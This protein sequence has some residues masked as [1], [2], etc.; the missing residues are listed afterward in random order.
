MHRFIPIVLLVEICSTL[1]IA[2]GTTDTPVRI[3]VLD[4]LAA[5]VISWLRYGASVAGIVCVLIGGLR[6]W[7]GY[8]TWSGRLLLAG[9]GLFVLA[10]IALS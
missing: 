4:E 10:Y 2:A 8:T 3:P 9:V 6:L 1:G 7:L 5:T